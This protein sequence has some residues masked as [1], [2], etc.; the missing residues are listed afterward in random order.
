MRIKV[1]Y[2]RSRDYRTVAVNGAVGGLAADRMVAADL[3]VERMSP[4]EHVLMDVEGDVTTSEQREPDDTNQR[5]VEREL[6][7]GLVLTP[8]TARAVAKWL[9][10]TA[11][12]AEAGTV[13]SRD[14]GSS[15]G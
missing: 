12:K 8:T 5:Y 3:F 11:D 6:Q 2:T 15:D 10:D 13:I 1:T 7:V 14:V 9:N 4:P